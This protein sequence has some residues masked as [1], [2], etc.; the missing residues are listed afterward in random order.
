LSRHNSAKADCLSCAALMTII[1]R[2]V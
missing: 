1:Q 2:V